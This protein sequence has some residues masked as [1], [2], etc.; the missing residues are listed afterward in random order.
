MFA[1]FASQVRYMARLGALCVGGVCAAA[2]IVPQ[3]HAARPMVIDDADLVDPQACQL[4]SWIQANRDSTE[5]WTQ[6]ACNF[7]GNL[8]WAIGGAAT[9]QEGH[10]RTTDLVLQGKT[11]FKPLEK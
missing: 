1:Q 5:F 10:T 6:P 4:E 7:T 3:V 2:F 11:L 9:R 8:E